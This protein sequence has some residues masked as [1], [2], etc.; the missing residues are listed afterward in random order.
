MSR[1]YKLQVMVTDTFISR[2]DALCESLDCSRS[3]L[4]S[5]LLNKSI[6]EMEKFGNVDD[7]YRSPD[8][9]QQIKLE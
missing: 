6:G 9:F 2:L 1:N 4:C 3:T 8:T 5:I 7:T